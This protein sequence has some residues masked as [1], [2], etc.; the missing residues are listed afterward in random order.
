VVKE[1]EVDS[2][3]V[4]LCEICGLGYK[5]RRTAEECEEWCRRTNS[6]S[7]EITKKAIYF[8]SHSQYSDPIRILNN[9]LTNHKIQNLFG[10]FGG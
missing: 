3:A 1:I 8:P 10:F 4:F 2:K 7:I 9:Y 6:C 5:E